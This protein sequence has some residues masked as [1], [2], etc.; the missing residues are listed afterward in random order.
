GEPMEQHE[1]GL[2]PRV[3]AGVQV[4]WTARDA[5]LPIVACAPHLGVAGTC[6]SVGCHRVLPVVVAVMGS[7]TPPRAGAGPS[8]AAKP[9]DAFRLLTL[10]EGVSRVRC[11]APRAAAGRG[12]GPWRAGP[13]VPPGRRPA[14]RW[15]SSRRRGRR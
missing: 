12:R 2:Y 8:G 3:L 9:A 10:R 14:Q 7:S 11:G 5:V 6:L 1:G 13:G 15:W 4:M